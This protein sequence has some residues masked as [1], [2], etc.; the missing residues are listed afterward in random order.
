MTRD[1]MYIIS[2]SFS[3]RSFAYVLI[4][5][6]EI[7][8]EFQ[9][10]IYHIDA[11]SYDWLDSISGLFA[12][13]FH[14]TKKGNTALEPPPTWTCGA[15]HI[16]AYIQCVCVCDCV[17]LCQTSHVGTARTTLASSFTDDGKNDDDDDVVYMHI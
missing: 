13:I 17:L 15:K 6:I 14:S 12:L 2:N 5:A 7:N 11:Y 1:T 4:K 10:Y 16:R 8:G 3:A 9:E